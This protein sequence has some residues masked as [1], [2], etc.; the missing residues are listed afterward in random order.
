MVRWHHWFNRHEFEQTPGDS[1]RRNSGVLRSM[2]LYRVRHDWE[3]EQH[4]YKS[5]LPV[6]NFAT[7]AYFCNQFC[8][9]FA[10]VHVKL[11]QSC[12]TFCNPKDCSP[13]G[14][15]SHGILQTR[16]LEWV[17]MPSRGS[18]WPRDGTHISCLLHWQACSL[19]LAPP[20]KPICLLNAFNYDG[21][22]WQLLF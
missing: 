7:T 3:T 9:Y 20:E 8:L 4:Y 12:E 14:S 18:S 17:A 21:K 1:E 19:P 5:S 15:F 11:L 2:G 16:I 22:I 13:L 10:C 6:R